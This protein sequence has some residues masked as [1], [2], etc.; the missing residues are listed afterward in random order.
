[1][2]YNTTVIYSVACRFVVEKR[3]H[4]EQPVHGET[5]IQDGAVGRW[6]GGPVQRQTQNGCVARRGV[7]SDIWDGHDDISAVLDARHQLGQL[8]RRPLPVQYNHININIMFLG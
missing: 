4:R 5:G 6:P 3:N 7:Q 1:M 8:Q 2:D